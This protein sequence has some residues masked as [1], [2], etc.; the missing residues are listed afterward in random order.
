M[1]RD[2][3]A[4]TYHRVSGPHVEWANALLERLDLRGDETV[5]DAGCGSGRV[6][7]M[8]LERLPRG[9]VVAVDQAPSMVEHAR[10]TLAEAIGA[11][12]AEPAASA[13]RATVLQA[14]LMEL[15]LERPVDAVFSNAVFHWVPDHDRLF[16]RLHAALRP[17]GRLVAQCGGEGNVERFHRAAREA[18][19]EPPFAE[20]LQGWQG[21]WNFAGPKQ[22]AAR[23]ERAGFERVETWLEPYPVVPDDPAGYLRSVCL[24]Y[25]LEQLP[26]PLRDEFVE[27]VRMRSCAELDYV[28][29]NIGAT[30]R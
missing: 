30:R 5:L 15:E 12:P 9:H 14:E 2:W 17:G 29:L 3:D 6:T 18:A 10:E 28:R 7:L 11:P 13:G 27:A 16:G 24:G 23:L 20:H 22:T 1:T 4:A 26:E 25:H 19:A 8:L 21:P